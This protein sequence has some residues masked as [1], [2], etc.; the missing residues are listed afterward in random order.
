MCP[1]GYQ[2]IF[3]AVCTGKFFQSFGIRV[4]FGVDFNECVYGCDDVVNGVS[5][6]CSDSTS[7][8]S[9]AINQRLC[10]CPVDH[11]IYG[12]VG[13][14]QQQLI[15]AS[16]A[17][18]GCVDCSACPFN[19]YL[20]TNCTTTTNRV[21]SVCSDC[22]DGMYVSSSCTAT[23]SAVCSKCTV[24]GDGEYLSSPCTAY[25]DAVCSPCRPPCVAPEVEVS[26]VDCI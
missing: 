2:E 1:P 22:S 25:A 9:L 7:D 21:C 6:S 17:F 18:P 14:P 13:G 12:I 4:N 24:C 11:A 15:L 3:P 20:L 23:S 16:G 10:T 8:P 26:F 5:V 19:S